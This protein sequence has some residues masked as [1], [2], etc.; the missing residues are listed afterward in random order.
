M[1]HTLPPAPLCEEIEVPHTVPPP[2]I[3]CVLCFC[4]T[5]HLFSL[6]FLGGFKQ[7]AGLVYWSQLSH[8]LCDLHRAYHLLLL[9]VPRLSDRDETLAYLLRSPWGLH[10]MVGAHRKGSVDVCYGCCFYL[11]PPLGSCRTD[12]I[13]C[14]LNPCGLSVHILC[15]TD[16]NRSFAE[17][18]GVSRLGTE[19]KGGGQEHGL[20]CFPLLP[21]L[22]LILL[23]APHLSVSL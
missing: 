12:Y 9:E 11:V 16:N 17:L 13:G 3:L 4:F 10:E 23:L 7:R 22:N 14:L 15:K 5:L 20:L 21:H 2:L 6:L 8:L 19:H 1:T 18:D